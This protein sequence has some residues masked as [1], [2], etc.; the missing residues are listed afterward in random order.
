MYS[1]YSHGNELLEVETEMFENYLDKVII[2][3]NIIF[4]FLNI[5]F[6]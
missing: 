6:I 4:N 3:N 5:K 2:Y 1:Q